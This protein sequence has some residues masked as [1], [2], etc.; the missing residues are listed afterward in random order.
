MDLVMELANSKS[1]W[2]IASLVIAVVIFQSIKFIQL[3][4]KASYDAGMS[5]EEVKRA[6]KTGAISSLGPSIAVAI[7]AISLIAFLGNPLTMLRIGVIGSAPIESA[8][9]TLAAESAGAVLGGA[10][11]TREV[12]T[13]IVWV[14]CI[15]GSG[16]LVFTALF[17]KSLGKMQKKLTSAGNG[18][19]QKI[20]GIVASAAMIGAFGYLVSAELIKGFNFIIVAA[21]S[22]GFMILEM[23]LADKYSRLNWLREWALGLAILVSLGVGYFIV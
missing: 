13:A 7:V 17:T 1:I 2:I 3:S 22:A 5:K 9:A 10:D 6:L 12:F 15:G 14:L 19:G 23:K 20:M 18:K 16:W 21:V 11:Y 4:I 8:G